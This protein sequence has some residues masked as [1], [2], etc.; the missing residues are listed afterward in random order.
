M[1]HTI[2]KFNDE[3]LEHK[4]NAVTSFPGDG[5][6]LIFTGVEQDLS[7]VVGTVSDV[8]IT[9]EG[10][11]AVCRLFDECAFMEEGYPRYFAC[12]LGNVKDGIVENYVMT[13]VSFE[14]PKWEHST[15]FPFD[16]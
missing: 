2:L 4:I 16:K 7:K 13:H 9:E 3:T 11:T 8:E 1:R 15:Y 6:F 5:R 10:V 12:G 14:L